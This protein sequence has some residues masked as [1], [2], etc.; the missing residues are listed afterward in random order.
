MRERQP[1]DFDA[2]AKDICAEHNLT[3]GVDVEIYSDLGIVAALKKET[4][5]IAT[6]I[7]HMLIF[8][9]DIHGIHTEPAVRVFEP[10]DGPETEHWAA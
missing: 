2:V 8:R 7:N 6:A 3:V 1:F 10:D 9:R 5:G 4:H